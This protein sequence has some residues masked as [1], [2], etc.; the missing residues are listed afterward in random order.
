MA[1]SVAEGCVGAYDTGYSFS[2]VSSPAIVVSPLVF[3][4]CV[5]VTGPSSRSSA[6]RG[7]GGLS[8]GSQP[9]NCV[10]KISSINIMNTTVC[11][12]PKPSK[13]PRS[14]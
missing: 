12:T 2:D 9:G 7:G 10:V 1:S 14:L 6:V 5:G 3:Y 8:S 13:K 4:V 11:T